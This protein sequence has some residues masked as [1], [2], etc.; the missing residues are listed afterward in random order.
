MN[1]LDDELNNFV[2]ELENEMLFEDDL[3]GGKSK[4]EKEEKKEKAEKERKKA[5]KEREEKMKKNRCYKKYSPDFC[6]INYGDWKP[7]NVC[8]N[9]S[10]EGC[11]NTCCPQKPKKCNSFD[12][13]CDKFQN[14]LPWKNCGTLK[15][16]KSK[17]Q[18]KTTCCEEK[19]TYCQDFKNQTCSKPKHVF[20]KNKQFGLLRYSSPA[21]KNRREQVCCSEPSKIFPII[22]III[23]WLVFLLCLIIFVRYPN[24][25]KLFNCNKIIDSMNDKGF[26]KNCFFTIIMIFMGICLLGSGVGVGFF[27]KLIFNKY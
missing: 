15:Q 5:E 22:I 11:K 27:S 8:F 2:E 7:D 13:I 19:K 25:A 17:T 4:E 6:D 23:I 24:W 21:D 10:W 3:M 20:H 16:D 18:C 12:S 9:N 26:V 14:H 1:K